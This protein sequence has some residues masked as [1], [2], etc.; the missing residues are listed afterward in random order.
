MGITSPFSLKPYFHTP[1]CFFIRCFIRRRI[2]FFQVCGNQLGFIDYRVNENDIP[3]IPA[4][5]NVVLWSYP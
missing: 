2:I 5:R 3:V 4:F 1:Y